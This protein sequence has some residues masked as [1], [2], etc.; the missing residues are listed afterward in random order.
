MMVVVS[1]VVFAGALATALAVIAFAVGPLWSRI[2]RVIAGQADRG[3]APLEQLVRAERR[4]A[5]RRRASLP[6]PARRLREVA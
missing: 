3:F 6:A 1:I 2:L 5:V 4:I